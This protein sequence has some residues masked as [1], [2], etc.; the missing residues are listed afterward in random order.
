M[1]T[2]ARI[3]VACLASY[4]NG[5]LHGRWI[6]VDPDVD[7]MRAEI[8]EMLAASPE[9]GAEEWAIH[10][11]EGF[12]DYRV[13]EYESLTLLA[14]MAQVAEDKNVP[15]ACV[16]GFL[17]LMGCSETDL[18]EAFGESYRGEWESFE[19]FAEHEFDELHLDKVPEFVR[20]YIDYDKYARD[21]EPEFDWVSDGQGS[22]WVFQSSW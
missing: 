6:D 12:G 7:M 11:Y 19:D 3:Y 16:G 2:E 10:D 20:S 13:S 18:R 9:P 1:T 15:V 17:S 4:N 22:V 5:R 21:L 8:A 14:I